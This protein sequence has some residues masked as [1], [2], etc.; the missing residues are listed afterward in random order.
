[1]IVQ[2]PETRAEFKNLISAN[3]SKTIVVKFYADW[4]GPC[5]RIKDLVDTLFN[6]LH[7]DKLMIVVNADEQRDV[8]SYLKIDRLPTIITY[9]G[10]E[11]DNVIMTSD[12]RELKSF[13]NS[14]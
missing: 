1:M 10:G 2:S 12:E 13:F 5:K 8:A 3:K 4:C 9:K 6:N 14:L 7:G 11:R